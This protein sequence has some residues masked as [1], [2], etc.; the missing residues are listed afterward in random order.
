MTADAAASAKHTSQVKAADANDV[1][2][3]SMEHAVCRTSLMLKTAAH[4]SEPEN[5]L[6]SLKH[7][8]KRVAFFAARPKV[9]EGESQSS[10]KWLS[11]LTLR[12]RC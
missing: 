5:E 2:N 3:A 11:E 4:A 6:P 7:Q 8:R 10:L 9:R 1:L 12:R